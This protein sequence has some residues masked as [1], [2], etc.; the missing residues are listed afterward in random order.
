M[1]EFDDCL[2]QRSISFHDKGLTLTEVTA[3]LVSSITQKRVIA[4]SEAS[5]DCL[6]CDLLSLKS[7]IWEILETEIGDLE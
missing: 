2:K 6:F 1:L 7:S 4:A 3:S 5:S